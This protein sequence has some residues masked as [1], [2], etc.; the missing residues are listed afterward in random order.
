MTPVLITPVAGRDAETV[1]SLP[2]TPPLAAA[3]PAD[4]RRAKPHA[5]RH[6]F[7]PRIHL[8]GLLSDKFFAWGTLRA[9][10][11]GVN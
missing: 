7:R 11:C 10:I 8:A 2:L 5:G 3:L 1:P 9:V 6:D 4:V